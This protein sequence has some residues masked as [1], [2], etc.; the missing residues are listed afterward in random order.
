MSIGKS[1]ISR[2]EKAV[3]KE[4]KSEAAAVFSVGAPEVADFKTTPVSAPKSSRPKVNANTLSK[5]KVSEITSTYSENSIA[6][7]V[8]WK[9][10]VDSVE[11]YGIIEPLILR[12]TEDGYRVIAG[13]KRLFA[14][15]KLGIKEVDAKVIQARDDEAAALI[16]EIS[17][18]TPDSA[19]YAKEKAI[20]EVSNRELPDYLL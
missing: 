16:N 11:K 2:A 10:L 13:H 18:F 3:S 9:T 15:K 12:K 6:C 14:A 7:G 17:K 5:V 20:A 4:K 8:L 1:S 19:Y